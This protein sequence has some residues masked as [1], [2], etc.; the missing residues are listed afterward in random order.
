[1]NNYT[2]C[3]KYFKGIGHPQELNE[4]NPNVVELNK[5][6]TVKEFENICKRFKFKRNF[7][8]TWGVDVD[9]SSRKI[10]SMTYGD[11]RNSIDFNATL[12]CVVLV[13]VY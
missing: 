13:D 2:A 12:N 10:Y 8:A 9:G 4:H 6:M 5:K 1:M 11:S 7:Y 3:F